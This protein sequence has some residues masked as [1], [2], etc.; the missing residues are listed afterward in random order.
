MKNYF[1]NNEAPQL[2]IEFAKVNKTRI[3]LFTP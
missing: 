2:Q 1:N 3:D